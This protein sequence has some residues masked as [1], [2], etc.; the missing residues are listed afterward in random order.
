MS[1]LLFVSLTDGPG[2]N[3]ETLHTL[4]PHFKGHSN[5]AYV[6]LTLILAE[7]LTSFDP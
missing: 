4:R 2:Q 7:I 6:V 5:S 1:I 3:T